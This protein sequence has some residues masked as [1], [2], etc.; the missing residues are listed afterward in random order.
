L[1]LGEGKEKATLY[2]ISDDLRID[3]YINYTMNHYAERVKIY[4]SE[5][6]K[7]S[8]YKVELPNA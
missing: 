6:F 4:H 7:I 8:T 5:K 3:N 1:R 2:D